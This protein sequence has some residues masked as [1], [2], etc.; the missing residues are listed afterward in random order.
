MN[1]LYHL[2]RAIYCW[3]DLWDL[4]WWHNTREYL[5]NVDYYLDCK[6][7]WEVSKGIWLET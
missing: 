6:T 2:L 1:K 7:A 5:D 4:C 3:A